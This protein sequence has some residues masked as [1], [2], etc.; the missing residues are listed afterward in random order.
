MRTIFFFL[1]LVCAIFAKP[2]EDGF[3]EDHA[4]F[5]SEDERAAFE[6][7]AG[8]LRERVGF[9]IYIYSADDEVLDPAAAADSICGE[10]AGDSARAVIFVDRTARFRAFA[11]SQAAEKFLSKESAERLAQKFLLPEFR[12]DHYGNGL[13]LLGAEMAKNVARWHD[14][15]LESPMPRPS[16]NGLPTIAWILI[17]AVAGAVIVAYAYFVR[18]AKLASRR[19]RIREFGGFPHQKF[20]SGFGG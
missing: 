9:S 20:N 17:L 3:V 4:K 6:R 10:A 15:R 5:L 14:V 7:I 13:I 2:F 8:E 18:Q 11:L 12:K 19:D 16:E 1:I